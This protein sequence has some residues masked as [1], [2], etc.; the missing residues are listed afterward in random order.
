MQ[1]ICVQRGLTCFYQ[2]G[3]CGSVKLEGAR[4][5]LLRDVFESARCVAAAAVASASKHVNTAP[6]ANEILWAEQHNKPV[7]L[8]YDSSK[9]LDLHLWEST[10]PSL[11][12]VLW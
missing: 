9:P 11:F 7:L 5:R 8:V 6:L 3:L 12:Q 2:K 10:W 4:R 1:T